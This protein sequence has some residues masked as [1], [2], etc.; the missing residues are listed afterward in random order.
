[1][2]KSDTPEDD[3]WQSVENGEIES[4]EYRMTEEEQQKRELAASTFLVPGI[5]LED[6][7][8]SCPYET[9]IP[10][11][12]ESIKN[13]KKTINEEDWPLSYSHPIFCNTP[14]KD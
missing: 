8:W 2:Q 3:H 9:P 4:F 10:V 12:E 14:K 11:D 7:L 1:M 5:L 6:G 13:F